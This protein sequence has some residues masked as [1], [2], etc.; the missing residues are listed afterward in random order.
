MVR[1]TSD[2]IGKSNAFIIVN[3]AHSCVFGVVFSY[4]HAYVNVAFLIS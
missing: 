4:L 3:L 1:R 2:A